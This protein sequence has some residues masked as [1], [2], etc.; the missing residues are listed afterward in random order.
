M[1]RDTVIVDGYNAIHRL[2]RLRARLDKGLEAARNQLV[3][4]C[5]AR[6]S[7]QHDV[8]RLWI[9]FDGKSFPSAALPQPGPRLKVIFSRSGES[10]DDRILDL[11][12]DMADTRTC[13]V[14]SDDQD[15][16][17]PARQLHARAMSVS[18]FFNAVT[19]RASAH[20]QQTASGQPKSLLTPSQEKAITEDLRRAWGI[21]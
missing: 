15:V 19:G 20:G 11:V 18:G 10:A 7:L 8:E 2:P 5:A 17:R 4:E 3:I 21:K 14:V 6:L 9:V 12:R 1:P 13:V 16:A